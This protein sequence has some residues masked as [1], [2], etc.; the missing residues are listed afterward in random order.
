MSKSADS[1]DKLRD[2]PA[3]ELRN[4]LARVRDEVFRLELGRHTNQV[5]SSAEI[6]SKRRE[7]S[8][9]LTILRARELDL[10]TQGKKSKSARSA[11]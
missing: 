9:I 6:T 2:L 8:R 3:D 1:L 7:V 5:T 4:A 11:E 10:E